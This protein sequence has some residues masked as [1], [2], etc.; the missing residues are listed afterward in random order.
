ME[1]KYGKRGNLLGLRFLQRCQVSFDNAET[2]RTHL[3]DELHSLLPLNGTNRRYF[4]VVEQHAVELV[5][6]DQHLW[7]ERRRDEL[8]CARKGVYHRCER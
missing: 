3:V 8:R 7:P 5:C 1:N 2:W 4:L 6:R